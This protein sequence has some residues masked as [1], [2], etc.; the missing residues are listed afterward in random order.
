MGPWTLYFLALRIFGSY[1]PPPSDVLVFLVAQM[2]KNL[3][4][5][6]ETWVLA[7]GWEDPLEEGM[8]THSVFLPGESHGQRRLAGCSPIAES[9]M[10]E[11]LTLSLFRCSRIRGLSLL[12]LTCHRVASK[13][14]LC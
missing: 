3:P 13:S 10:T 9:D 11:P 12:P 14:G 8:A 4:A 5:M 2:V 7:L 1:P 6:Q